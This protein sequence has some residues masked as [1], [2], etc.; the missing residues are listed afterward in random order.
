[1]LNPF[2]NYRFGGQEYC[3]Y[4]R[5]REQQSGFNFVSRI[6]NIAKSTTRVELVVSIVSLIDWVDN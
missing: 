2:N 1:V 4:A 5:D 3:Q 6:R